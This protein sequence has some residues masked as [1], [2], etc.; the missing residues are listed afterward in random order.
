MKAKMVWA[1]QLKNGDLIVVNP[2]NVVTL[3]KDGKLV[4]VRYVV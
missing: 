4:R 3:G 2:Q 1:L